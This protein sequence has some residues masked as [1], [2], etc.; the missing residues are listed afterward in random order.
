MSCT[1]PPMCICSVGLFPV[2]FTSS[3]AMFPMPLDVE[4]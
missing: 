3:L 1:D 2:Q 4:S